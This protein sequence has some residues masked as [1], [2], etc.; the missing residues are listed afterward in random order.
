MLL[1]PVHF[2]LF[3]PFLL[4]AQIFLFESELPIR[5][6]ERAIRICWTHNFDNPLDRTAGYK[7]SNY[8]KNPKKNFYQDKEETDKSHA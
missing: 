4:G 2:P 8:V 5:D 3:T 7:M 6:I 1:L